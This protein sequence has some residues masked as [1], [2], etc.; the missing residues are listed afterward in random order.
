MKIDAELIRTMLLYSGWPVL[1]LGGFFLIKQSINFYK[2]TG[3]T[4][5]GK[6]VIYLTI[7]NLLTMLCLGFVATIY[8]LQDINAVIP[9]VLPIFLVWFL[10]IT[11]VS[12]IATG[13]DKQAIVYNSTITELS[14]AKDEFLAIASHQ[15]RTPLTSIKWSLD[16]ALANKEISEEENKIFNTV[17]KENEKLIELVS[18][19][20]SV[21]RI[22]TGKI[23]TRKGKVDIMIAIQDAYDI[24]KPLIQ[25]N[26][27]E[28]AMPNISTPV[29]VGA[30]KMLLTESVKNILSNS[31]KFGGSN[32]KIELEVKPGRKLCTFSVTNHGPEI[33]ETQKEKMF[34]KFSREEGAHKSIGQ[35]VG[36]LGLYITKTFVEANGGTIWYK[37]KQ[38]GT[39]FFFTVP[40]YTES[41]DREKSLP[42]EQIVK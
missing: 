16:M 6:L 24:L 42:A 23:N 41:M 10:V 31:I 36:G 30:D 34:K 3:K 2:S 7:S 13:L 5:L 20:L 37:S 40:S 33:P 8:M 9:I 12:L 39:T 25:K 22:E 35:E 21:A 11:I 32:T 29:Y 14:R 19:L 18:E 26:N 17:Y 38:D 28:V 1:V 27:Q 15:L 4:V